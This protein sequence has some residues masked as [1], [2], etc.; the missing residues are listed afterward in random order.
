MKCKKLSISNNTAISAIYFA[1]LQ[2]GYDFYTIERD[3]PTVNKLSSF[4]LSECSDYDFFSE[5]RQNTCETYP[6]WPRAAMLET[7]TFYM[8]FPQAY[9]VNFEAYRRSILSAQNISD[10]ERNKAFWDWIPQFPSALKDVLQS[11]C[12]SRYLEWENAWV[13]EQTEKY[14]AKLKSI[15]DAFV[16]CR[17]KFNSP[18]QSLQIVLNPIKCAY[19]ADYHRKGETFIFCSGSLHE[20]AVMHEFLHHSIHPA[21][22]NKK[23]EILRCSFVNPDLDASYYLDGGETGKLNAFEEYLVRRL[24]DK[25]LS[26]DIPE[27]LDV[28]VNYEMMNLCTQ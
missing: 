14:H 15:E 13:E 19:S 2:C 10:A 9:F 18:F 27:N 16:L 24:T 3:T 22:E 4:V 6:Y 1:L 23:S 25:I 28:F 8:E 12:F 21:V 20:E 11:Q 7:A 5:V 17:E 26:R